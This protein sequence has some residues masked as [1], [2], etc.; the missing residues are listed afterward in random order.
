MG[1]LLELLLLVFS[2]GLGS[3]EARPMCAA[4][5]VSVFPFL[6]RVVISSD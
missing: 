3:G 5:V 1:S 2:V 4:R 6:P